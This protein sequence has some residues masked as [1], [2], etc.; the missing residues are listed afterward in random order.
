M[1]GRKWVFRNSFS[2]LIIMV[3]VGTSTVQLSSLVLLNGDIVTDTHAKYFNSQAQSHES[4]GV[5]REQE[6]GGEDPFPPGTE[7]T[8]N[9]KS[10]SLCST[11]PD[12]DV[13]CENVGEGRPCDEVRDEADPN[14][15]CSDS[16][17]VLPKDG[18][19]VMNND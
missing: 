1:S 8:Y 15:T 18:S 14:L 16:P 11:T 17:I 3:L 12:S 9:S 7:W 4:G 5:Q 2:F 6:L 19:Y 13:H 10:G